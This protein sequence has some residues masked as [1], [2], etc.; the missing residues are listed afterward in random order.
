MSPTEE[1]RPHVVSIVVPVYQGEKTLLALVSEVAQFTTVSVTAAGTPW[2]VAEMILVFDNGPDRS[3]S[4]IRGLASE[5]DF[6]RSVWLS[7]N[8]GQHSATLAGIASSGSEWIVTLDEDGQHNPADI[9]ILLDAALDRQSPVVYARPVNA[10]PHGLM[11]NL[12]SRLAKSIIT[13]LSSGIQVTSFQSFRL[14]LGEIGRSVAAYAGSGV[15]L[16]VALS[17]VAPSPTTA[18]VELRGEGDRQSGYTGRKLFSHFWRLA[19]SSGTRAL[20]IVSMIGAVF[21]LGGIILAIA[22]AIQR[23]VG[24]DNLPAGWAS[25]VIIILVSSGAIL[26]SLGVVA[27]YLGFAVNMA[28]GKPSYLIVSDLQSGPLGRARR[29]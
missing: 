12:S 28:M 20:R 3:A 4:V 5:H 8:F 2:R 7:R 1:P 9:G 17:W 15:Y 21:A 23:I 18:D 26:F 14:I 10:A 6:V 24:G 19:L 13:G 22:F 29:P 25:T 16:D 11:R 27:E